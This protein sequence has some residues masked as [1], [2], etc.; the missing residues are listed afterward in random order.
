MKTVRPIARVLFFLTR[1][2]AI[3]IS[4]VAVYALGT[5]LLYE[6]NRSARLPIEVY[7]NGSFTIFYP[8]TKNPFLLGDYSTSY[9]VSNLAT[10]TFYGLF[11]WMLSGVFHAFK[12]TRIFTRKG[13]MQLSRFYMINLIVPF[14][15]LALLAIF[16]DEMI[17]IVRIILLH[18]VIGVFAFFM[19]AIFKQGL[20]LQE[21]QD[22]TF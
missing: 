2:L 17:D 18:L 5:I 6:N 22:L 19:A 4:I 11:L 8:F 14:V 7:S 16:G 20:L 12:Q 9:L 13:V 1:I 15:F 10:I 21:E 3:V